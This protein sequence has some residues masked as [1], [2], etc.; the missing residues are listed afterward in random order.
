MQAMGMHSLLIVPLRAHGRPLGQLALAR[1]L[2]D[3][4]A[5][6]DDDLQFARALA[7]HASLAVDNTRAYSVERAAAAGEEQ[8]RQL[9]ASEATFRGFLEAAPDA[10][11]VVNRAGEMVLVNS[12]TE[13][14][15][16]Y[17]RAELL[18]NSVDMLVPE[19][20][21]GRHPGHRRDYF[22]DPRVRSMGSSLELHGLRKNG[23]EFPV[24][25]SLSPL[26]TEQGLLVSSAIRDLSVRKRA[27]GKFRALLEAAPDAIV[28]VNRYGAIVIVNAQAEKLFGYPRQELLGQAVETLVPLRRPTSARWAPASSSM[29]CAKM[30]RNS[31]S[32]SA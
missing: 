8:L 30:A 27:E 6:N 20:L 11:V 25:I 9:R 28:I 32:K 10:V 29:G 14:L 5:F 24:E 31:R 7:D 12:Q 1:Y 22:S 16:G 4:P 15:F 2:S 23:T 26:E 13:Q 17:S 19:R 21:R 18:G 3:S